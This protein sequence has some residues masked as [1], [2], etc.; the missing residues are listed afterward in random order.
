M[1]KAFTIAGSPE[2]LRMREG[3]DPVR[4]LTPERVRSMITG[5]TRGEFAGLMWLLAA[6]YMGVESQDADLLALCERRTSALE[7]MDWEIHTVDPKTA[8][9]DATLAAEQEA[10]LR[11]TYERLDNLGAL[12]GHLALS[13]VRGVSLAEK[14]LNADGSIARIAIVQ[15]WNLARAGVNGAWYYNPEAKDVTGD[16]LGDDWKFDTRL[17]IARTA[18]RPL[19]A[20]ALHKFVREALCDRDWDSF[21]EIYGVPGGVVVGPPNIPP[22]GEKDFEEAATAIA[23]GGSGYLPNGSA[24]HAN[25]APSGGSPHEARMA[26]LQRKLILAGT[27]GQL[28]MLSSSTGLNSDQAAQHAEVFRQIA[29]K[30]GRQ[31]GELLNRSI[32]RDVLDKAFPARP[33]LAYWRLELNEEQDAGAAVERIAKLSTAGYR[34]SP[35]TV[36]EAS[37]YEVTVVGRPADTGA[38]ARAT[39]VAANREPAPSAPA[40]TTSERI[41]AAA[42]EQYAPLLDAAEALPD[43]AADP[44]AF[45]A[46]L[47]DLR[48][49]LPELLDP[50]LIADALEADMLAAA[51]LASEAANMAPRKGDEKWDPTKHPRGH[52]S[53]PGRFAAKALGRVREAIMKAGSRKATVHEAFIHPKHGSI[54]I[55]FG[56]PGDAANGYAGGWGLSHIRAKHPD[57]TDHDI[58]TLLTKG[59]YGAHPDGPLKLEV[60]KDKLLGILGRRDGKR[61]GAWRLITLHKDGK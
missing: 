6:P 17:L 58:A 14:E 10:A 44:Q 56:A 55:G 48:E 43:P 26:F 9:Y 27:G 53:N 22:D 11:E 34:V 19:A 1:P 16:I 13:A 45:Q 18:P 50:A 57:I 33:R 40:A 21:V 61:E 25:A 60:R 36:K 29:R 5:V 31:I 52:T 2:R 20:I 39:S 8:G 54:S 3:M 32:D 38:D 35:Q 47:A 59:R 24:Y 4:G 30:D 46:A 15:P 49:R 37:G 51:G 7:E 12:V 42:A 23:K 41:L 28:T